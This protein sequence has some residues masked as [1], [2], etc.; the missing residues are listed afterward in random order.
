MFIRFFSFL[1]FLVPEKSVA[2]IFKNGKIWKPTTGQN[3]NNYAPWP[4]FC[5]YNFLIL[6]TKCGIKYDH[7]H[8]SY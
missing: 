1:A 3:S 5:H 6:E 2:N 8:K 4:P 7:K